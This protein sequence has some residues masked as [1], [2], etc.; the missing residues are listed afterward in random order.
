MDIKMQIY[1]DLAKIQQALEAPKKQRN[2]FGK[3]NYRSC[4]DI[5]EALKEHLGEYAV[6]IEDEIIN[7]GDRYYVKAT[8][9][10]TNGK[11]G[12]SNHAYARE[13]LSKKGM[14]D[15]QITGATSSYARKYALN[16]LFA[17]DDSKDT[18]S[19]NTHDKKLVV[20]KMASNALITTQQMKMLRSLVSKK[21]IKIED[22]RAKYKV[23]T[24]KDLTK[25]Q[26]TLII[27]RLKRLPD[28]KKKKEKF[29]LTPKDLNWIGEEASKPSSD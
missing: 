9:T 24:T 27:D 12:I 21:G 10:F 26:T 3:Y 17:L 28:V 13:S 4:E 8:V 7:I 15:S 5:L 2:N 6:I 18:D 19:T 23:S 29:D 1:K 22:V 25:D 16:G 14:D 11:S 20:E